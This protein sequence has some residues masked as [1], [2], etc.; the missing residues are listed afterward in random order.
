MLI[1]KIQLNF[2]Y[3]NLWKKYLS[4][5]KQCSYE[6]G[7]SYEI[8]RLRFLALKVTLPNPLCL[9]VHSDYKYKSFS[10][11]LSDLGFG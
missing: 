8:S 2:K 5:Q 10:L 7:P 3:G 6:L 11:S 9:C 1:F 4:L